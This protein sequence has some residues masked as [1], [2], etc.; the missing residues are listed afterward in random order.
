MEWLDGRT[1]AWAVVQQRSLGDLER[2]PGGLD[3]KLIWVK[4]LVVRI[5]QQ[6]PS[7]RGLPVGFVRVAGEWRVNRRVIA[8]GCAGAVVIVG[9]WVLIARAREG[10]ARSDVIGADTIV[11]LGD[12]ITE[13]ADW[14]ALLPTWPIANRG[15]AGHTTA[16]LLEEVDDVASHR[17]RSVVILTGTND[18]RDELPA[19]WTVDRLGELIVRLRGGAPDTVVV[20]QTVLPRADARGPVRAVNEAIRRLA[21][22]RGVELLDLYG[23]FDDGTGA[24][25]AAETT[26]GIHLTAA[27]YERWAVALDEMLRSLALD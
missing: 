14:A 17:P 23:A 1:G 4:A 5:G 19:S 18:I 6:I 16:Q 8:A 7:E 15:Y 21:S 13:Q 20:L 22:E 9:V 10:R 24:L 26:D 3:S 27:G 11:M 2:Q 25:R 12:S